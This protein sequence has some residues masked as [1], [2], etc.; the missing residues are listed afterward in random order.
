MRTMGLDVGTKTVGIAVSDGLGITAQGITTIRRTGM[1]ADLA[2]L[3][4]LCEEHEVTRLVVGLPLN[5]D[6]SEGPR[7]EASR[8]FGEA[9]AAQTGLE[10]IYWDERLT[11]VAAQRVLLEADVSR[12]KRR[13]VVDQIAAQ[14]ILQGWLD[15]QSNAAGTNADYDPRD[16]ED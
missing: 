10:V 8:K 1:K 14:L 9:A 13:E 3:K 7:A 11:T 16:Y 12:K 6:G 2:E 15:G 4:R 5:M